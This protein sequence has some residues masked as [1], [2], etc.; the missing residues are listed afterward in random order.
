MAVF[1]LFDGLTT[2]TVSR[3]DGTE[4]ALLSAVPDE[5]GAVVLFVHGFTGAKE[6]YLFVLP[7][8]RQH[9]LAAYAMDLRGNHQSTS[10]GPF[11]LDA[12]A[13]D[14]A[15]VAHSLADR[16]H[17]VAHSFG[18]LAAQ[19]AVI[20]D[21]GV[22]ASLTLMCSGPAGL[23][24]EPDL[25]PITIDRVT[26]FRTELEGKSL[27]EA[28][29][30]KTAYE[31]VD[32]HP[33]MQAFLRDRFIAGDHAAALRNIDDLLGAEDRVDEVAA[34]QV[35]CFVLYGAN[36]G[37][38]NQRTQNE[39]ARRLGTEPVSVP[40][41]THLPMLENVDATVQVLLANVAAAESH[42]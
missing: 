25:V 3:P 29:D 41:A 13:A 20:Q 17:L 31:N 33:A 8:L 34:T 23:T 30:A 1:D 37:T 40:E 14:V 18:G 26:R 42:R 9:G 24:A 16:V 5:P 12:L 15:A 11:D 38:W 10:P 27:A 6:D 28:W 4:L 19:R 39:M 36:D 7:E 2:S 35:P 32:M 21:P 22:F